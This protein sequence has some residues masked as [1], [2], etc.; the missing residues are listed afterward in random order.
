MA[1]FRTRVLSIGAIAALHRRP[2]NALRDRL[3]QDTDRR[4]WA[5]RPVSLARDANQVIDRPLPILECC[6]ILGDFAFAVVRIPSVNLDRNHEIQGCEVE[7]ESIIQD[8]H[9]LAAN[10]E[11]KFSWRIYLVKAATTFWL[12]AK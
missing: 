5:F 2:A 1:F 7:L 10:H 3:L 9:Q 11:I 6:V 4:S 8:G 12:A